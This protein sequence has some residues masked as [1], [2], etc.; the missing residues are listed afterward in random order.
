MIRFTQGKGTGDVAVF[1]GNIPAE[2]AEEAAKSA[3]RQVFTPSTRP[4]HGKIGPRNVAQGDGIKSPST[5]YRGAE[6]KA[7]VMRRGNESADLR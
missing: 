7:Y 2:D 6:W 4:S 5:L 1:S 3:C